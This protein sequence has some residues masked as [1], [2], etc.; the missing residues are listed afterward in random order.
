MSLFAAA[1]SRL[2]F[3]RRTLRTLSRR[4]FSRSYGA[5]LPSSLTEDRSST[6]GVF[7]LPTSVGVRY[8]LPLNPDPP[9]RRLPAR[10][11]R[12]PVEAFLGGQGHHATSAPPTKRGARNRAQR[13]V[14]P[15]C[16]LRRAPTRPVRPGFAWTSASRGPPTL[17]IRS[18]RAAYRVPPFGTA[19]EWQVQDYQPVRHRLRWLFL[20]FATSLGLGPD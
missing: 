3:R 18:A 10:P 5:N 17:S 2:V 6:V 4:P 9:D 16:P 20:L 11:R 7:P 15:G 13:P 14:V 8:G 19:F 1:S 12:R